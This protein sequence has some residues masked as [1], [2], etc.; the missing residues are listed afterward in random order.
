M[1]LASEKSVYWL[2]FQEDDTYIILD[3]AQWIKH[4][5]VM[6]AGVQTP[7]MTREIMKKK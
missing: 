5:P 4:L 2:Y 1:N 3:I 7:D 6:Q